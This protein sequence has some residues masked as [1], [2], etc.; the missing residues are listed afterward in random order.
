MKAEKKS[1]FIGL[2]FKAF[3]EEKEGKKVVF[4][5]KKKKIRGWVAMW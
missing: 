4:I 1:S 3:E 2:Q 5:L